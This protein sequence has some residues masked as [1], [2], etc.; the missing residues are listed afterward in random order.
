MNA[1]PGYQTLFEILCSIIAK[2][3]Q[4][5]DKKHNA[6]YGE[7]D[8]CIGKVLLGKHKEFLIDIDHFI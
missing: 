2:E 3:I 8:H 5:C 4:N 6:P 7:V 1:I